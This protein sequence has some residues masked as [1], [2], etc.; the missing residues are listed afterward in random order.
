MRIG[1]ASMGIQIGP[2]D[3][4]T[5][6]SRKKRMRTRL[7]VSIEQPTVI[8]IRETFS[9]EFPDKKGNETDD[10]DTTGH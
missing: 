5:F 10:S 4:F 8:E 6:F 3:G 2:F 7:L 9:C 1:C